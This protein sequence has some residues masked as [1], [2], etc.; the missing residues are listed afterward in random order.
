MPLNIKKGAEMKKED[1]SAAL[2]KGGKWALLAFILFLFLLTTFFW[3]R[4]A[5]FSF[6]IEQLAQRTA[7]DK[8]LIKVITALLLIPFWIGCSYALSVRRNKRHTGFAILVSLYALYYLG[9][10]FATM[11]ARFD[12]PHW[13]VVT[14]DCQVRYFE[15]EGVDLETGQVREPVTPELVPYLRLVERHGCEPIDPN[16]AEFFNRVTGRSQAYYS[17]LPNGDY[18]FYY[19]QAYDRYGNRSLPVTKEVVQE[20]EKSYISYKGTKTQVGPAERPQSPEIE[21]SHGS[22]EQQRIDD[23]RALVNTGM[24]PASSGTNVGFVVQTQG[25]E[26]VDRLLAAE[27]EQPGLHLLSDYFKPAFKQSAHFST[28][29]GGQTELLL[30][31]NVMEPLSYLLLGT[32]SYSCRRGS[33]GYGL[34]ACDID[35]DYVILDKR[36]RLLKS[37][38]VSVTGP[39]ATESK[40]LRRGLELMAENHGA[41][42]LQVV[43]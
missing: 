41:R 19:A 10:H 24:R 15:D 23:F 38:M 25:K 42:I 33:S 37:D 11:D 35:F 34:Y 17:R 4:Q 18:E 6:Y 20:W 29:A 32:I 5:V 7:L 3:I 27:L 8:D 31:S 43:H 13:F 16:K 9:L 26:Q 2:R 14:S 39:G 30:K 12:K 28:I 21:Q 36:G 22:A 40:A 1:I